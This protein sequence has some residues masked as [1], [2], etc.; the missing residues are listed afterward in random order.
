MPVEVIMNHIEIRQQFIEFFKDK[1]HQYVKSSPVVPID[2]QTLLFANAGMNQFKDIFLGQGQRDYN[3][4]VNTQK[5]IRVSGKHNDLEEVGHDTYHHTFFEMLGN[6]S[7]GDYYK[8]EA[9][10][11]AW[12]LLTDVWQLPK[13]KLYATVFESDDEAF[14]LWRSETDINPDHILRF[15]HKDNFW[16]MGD[17]G[18]C[19]PCSEIHID[20][21]EDIF[22][23]LG[24]DPIP[25]GVNADSPRFIELWNLVFIQYNRDKDGKLSDLPNKHVDTGMGF[26]R[27][28]AV[29]QQVNSN[30]EIDLFQQIIKGIEFLTEVDYHKLAEQEKIPYRVIADH[31]RALSFAIADGAMPAN[32]GRGYVL[33]RILRRAARYGRTLGLKEPFLYQLVDSV[34]EAMGSVFSEIGEKKEYIRKVIQ[35]EENLFNRTL[36]KGLDIFNTEIQRLEENATRIFPG[37]VAFKLYDTFGF[38]LDLTELMA[39][40][41]DFTVDHVGFEARMAEQRTRAKNATDFRLQDQEN[42]EWTVLSDGAGS[43]FCGYDFLKQESQIRKYALAESGQ[44]LVV[45][46]ATPFYA[47]SGGQVADRGIIYNRD[48]KAEVVDVRKINEETVHFCTIQ[49]GHIGDTAGVT[50]EVQDEKRRLTAYNHTATHLLHA[51]LRKYLGTHVQQAGS[52]V[53]EN[54]LRFDF[55]HFQKLTEQELADIETDVNR[56]I[57]RNTPLEISVK[58]FDDAKAA[59]AMALFGEKYG[60]E[61]RV[62]EI[63]EYSVELCGGTHVRST[64][65]IGMFK[66]VAETSIASGTRRIE[67][68]T[69][70]GV[71]K[72]FDDYRN[73]MDR[74][75]ADLNSKPEDIIGKISQLLRD[76]KALE[77]ELAQKSA[78]SLELE[79]KKWIDSAIVEG[80]IKVIKAQKDGLDTNGLKEVGDMLRQ[81]G[82]SKTI[83]LVASIANE[84]LMFVCALT[85]DLVKSGTFHAGKMVGQV[86]KTAGGGGGGKP[87]LA[88]AG[89]RFPEKLEQA[90]TAFDAMVQEAQSSR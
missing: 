74:I 66:I 8:K 45:L 16:E 5:C 64:G 3:R 19:G 56:Q 58:S 69:A 13:D 75:A 62:V 23:K 46:D 31:I 73:T 41:K 32:E 81:F 7:F 36:D 83:G 80:D 39:G 6:W 72:Q 1:A 88:T 12:E 2:D 17:T 85:D 78:D 24:I 20:L 59:G 48:F 9:I 42:I 55:T 50:A 44:W 89:A 71:E 14:E 30:Y 28:C 82:S 60:D 22:E 76:K 47:E 57:R 86:A 54:R 4:A 79:V 67:A 29:L 43:I 68:I 21:G 52:L 63:P 90:F 49:S 33:R 65:E 84:K 70:I 87:H 77:K 10:T 15:G 26:E 61:V 37:D 51:A 25:G 27:I 11:W 53:D 18:P 34:E 35:A 38:P 40:E